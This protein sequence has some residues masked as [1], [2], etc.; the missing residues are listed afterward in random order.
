MA[1]KEHG[2]LPWKRLVDPADQARARRLP[3]LGRARA[4]AGRRPRQ[5]EDSTRRRSR[6]SRRT[7][8]RTRPARRLKQ[9]DLARTLERIAAQG[10]DGFYKG[11]T[12]RLLEKEMQAQRR[13]DHARRTWRAT[14]RRSATPVRGT[15]R[16]YDVLSM[17]PPSSGGVALIEMLNIL[18]GF[19]LAASGFGSARDH[20]PDRRGDAPRLCRS[21]PLPRRSRLQSATCRSTADLEG[22][23][24]RRCGRPSIRERAS[25]V[26][27]DDI[28]RGRAESDETTHFSVVDGERNAVSITYT[29]EAGLRLE[30]RRA[31]APA[32]CSTT[33]WA[34]STPAPA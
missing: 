16:G 28:R 25:Q 15:Y 27:A 7:A 24:G 9:P 14:R 29:L 30:D 33:R 19:D 8:C 17:P 11:E 31:R 1:W 4:L 23:R 22:L 6:S 3:D 26:L 18:E 12:A 13:A 32:S 5:H 34:I 20:A 2:K 10:P 21:R